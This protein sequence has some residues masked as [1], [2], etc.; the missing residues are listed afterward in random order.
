MANPYGLEFLTELIGQEETQR[1]EFKSSRALLDMNS[2]KRNKFISDQV[3]PTISAFLNTDGGRLIIGIEDRGGVAQELSAG[4]PRTLVRWEQ[5]QST[6]CDRIQPA[7]AG[8]VSV[9][10]VRVGASSDG[11]NLFAFVVD[12][13]PGTTAY[14]ADDRKYYVRRSGQS[15]A[16]EDKDVRLRMLAGDKPR[17]VIGLQPRIVQNVGDCS[18]YVQHVAWNLLFENVGVRTIPR[19]IVRSKLDMNGLSDLSRQAVSAWTPEYRETNFPVGGLDSTGLLPGQ[20][21]ELPL[22][23]VSSTAFVACGEPAAV[24]M[25]A[26]VVVYV[27]DGLPAELAN[28]DLM[29]DLLPVVENNWTIPADKAPPAPTHTGLM[30]H[31]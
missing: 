9:F 6:I 5:L 14:Q 20:R 31:G 26:N 27:D 24:T 1:L 18:R 2:Q 3:V 23:M 22:V 11:E 25:S 28:Y 29:V 21:F 19:A 4:V 17:L 15:E 12:V 30:N 7:V 10:P 13:K 8:Y 16:M